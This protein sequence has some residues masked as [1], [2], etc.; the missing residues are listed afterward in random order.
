MK[1][2]LHGKKSLTVPALRVPPAAAGTVAHRAC[3]ASRPAPAGQP[4]VSSANV[5]VVKEGDKVA[6]LIVTCGC[7]ER[8]EIDCIYPVGS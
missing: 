3:E 2:F 6:R 8:I 4:V 7:G 5:E 1:P